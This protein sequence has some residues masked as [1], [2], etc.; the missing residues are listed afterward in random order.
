MRRVIAETLGAVAGGYLLL[1]GGMAVFQRDFIYHPATEPPPPPAEIGLPEMVPVTM[2]TGDG[3]VITGWYAPAQNPRAATVVLFHGNAGTL[4]HRARKARAFLDA[5]F[6]MFLAEYRG[7]GGNPGKP[8]EEGLYADARAVMT[9]LSNAG[10]PS[11]KVVVYGESLGSGVAVQM[12]AEAERL[13]ALVLEA[14]FTSL[15]DLAPPYLLPGSAR[16]LMVDRYDNA[17]KIGPLEMPLLIIH[18]EQDGLVPA[19]MGRALFA[20]ATAAEK[21]LSIHPEAAHNDVWDLG[22]GEA[23]LDFLARRLVK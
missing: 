14:P 4:A 9:W 19:A 23:A 5:G 17:A 15:P 13:A 7:Y 16:L 18:G 3:Y 11:A 1:T 22:G 12:A 21:E 20:A 6:G 2:I 10:I 8:S